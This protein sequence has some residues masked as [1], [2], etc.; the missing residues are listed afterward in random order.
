MPV[1]KADE[2][3]IFATM[4]LPAYPP[5]CR[6]WPLSMLPSEGGIASLISFEHI[7]GIVHNHS[8]YSDGLHSLED[9]ASYVQSQGYGYFVI[10]DHS[11]SA[12]YAGGLSIEQVYR[13]WEEIDAINKK[14]GGQFTVFKSIES[15]ILTDGSLDYPDEVLAGF[16]LVIAS[17]HSVLQMD[18]QKATSRLIKAI[19]HPATRILGHPTG[20]LLLARPGYPVDYKKIADACAANGVALELNANP[21]RLDIDWTWIPYAQEKGV[22]ISIN[23]DAHSKEA[24]HHVRYG[25]DAARKGLLYRSACLNAKDKTQF[26]DWLVA[27]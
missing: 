16:D 1:D 11:R 27:R 26:L 2:A 13:Q 21:Q 7:R 22:M 8:T 6:E 18:E 24:I 4:G 25:V 5:E 3:S 17:V 23:P 15:D 9:M 10:S 20:R 12:G 19:E 14:F